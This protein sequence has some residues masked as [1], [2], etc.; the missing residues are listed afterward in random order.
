[1]LTFSAKS[2]SRKETFS[3]ENVQVN[4]ITH[5][6]ALRNLPNGGGVI[7]ANA[8]YALTLS[9]KVANASTSTTTSSDYE[10]IIP[11]AF[12]IN[13]SGWNEITE[14]ITA[15]VSGDLPFDSGYRL[16]VTATTDSTLTADGITDTISYTLKAISTDTAPTTAWEF[17]ADELNASKDNVITGT[18]KTLGVDVED[19]STKTNGDYS[20]TITFTAEVQSAV[21]LSSLDISGY[22]FYYVEGETWG[23]AIANHPT[24]NS[25]WGLDS[26]ND[27]YYVATEDYV[28][29][30]DGAYR[31]VNTSNTIDSSKTYELLN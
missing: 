20:D 14:G 10:L 12:T 5:G 23:Q 29:Y 31:S 27:V 16:K 3:H 17:T 30:F 2:I 4:T 7:P 25:S 13:N 15:K 9:L 18:T 26:D 22:M 21:T 11:S 6:C 19:Y 28:V 8:D 24:E 1:M